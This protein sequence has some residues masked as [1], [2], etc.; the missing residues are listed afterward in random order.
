MK[1]TGFILGMIALFMFAVSST[2]FAQGRGVANGNDKEENMEKRLDKMKERLKLTD[3]QVSQIKEIN[4]T[5]ATLVSDAKAKEYSEPK[6]KLKA[7]KQI[8]KEQDEKITAVLDDAQKA[9][10]TKMKEEKKEKMKEN[11]GKRRGGRN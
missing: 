4:D 3:S 6:D 11:R 1:K 5:Y 7:I 2:S 10:W 8:R 9:E